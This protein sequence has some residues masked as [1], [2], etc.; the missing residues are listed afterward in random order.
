MTPDK[1]LRASLLDIIFEN[2][3]KSYGAY[4][5]RKTY[6]RTIVIAM[7][8]CLLIAGIFSAL[9][10]IQKKPVLADRR[11][12]PGEEYKITDVIIP[13]DPPKPPELP[14]TRTITEPAT[15]NVRSVDFVSRIQMVSD[16]I[17]SILPTID[18]IDRSIISNVSNPNGTDPGTFIPANPGNG[19]TGNGT[20]NIVT[21]A[22]S[23]A[24]NDKV[25]EPAM[26][27]G[28][29]SAL[30]K[31]LE[32]NLK[33]P[34]GLEEG[35]HKRVV[36]TFVVNAEGAIEGIEINTSQGKVFDNEVIRVIKLMPGWKPAKHF[37]RNV[38]VYFSLPVIF[39]VSEE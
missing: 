36:A 7:L 6:D 24:G 12:K 32:Q 8:L 22:P 18:D 38:P 17:G 5:L 11:L 34:E 4:S 28:G 21:E 29:M 30:R 39:T 23:I 26:F 10:F 9:M 19:S 13:N 25:Q 2:R 16:N 27:P 20:S 35:E 33:V 3:N 37:G 15:M 31:F 1:I 14:S